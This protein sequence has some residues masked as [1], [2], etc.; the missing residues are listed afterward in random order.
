M[1]KFAFVP[2]FFA[3]ILI[4][5]GFRNTTEPPKGN[6]GA[7]TP[8]SQALGLFGEPTPEH[9]IPN[10]DPA[11]VIRG[12]ELV[13]AGK[14]TAPDGSTTKLQSKWYKCTACHNIEQEEPD[15]TRADPEARLQYAEQQDLPF[16]Q[17]TTFWGIVNRE[18]WYNDDYVK[19]YGAAMEKARNDIR[20]SIQLCS[21]GC[22]QG[23][24]LEEWEVDAVLSYFWSLQLNLGDLN[25]SPKEM[26]VL[27]QAIDN[28]DQH[29]KA[30][31][32]LKSKYLTKSPAHLGEVPED[33]EAGYG[34]TG[35]AEKGE[36]LYER[37][38]LTCHGPKGDS[39]YLTLDKSNY[40][41]SFF[42]RKITNGN[43]F[44]LYEIIRHGTHSVDGHKAYMPY[45]T[46]ERMSDQQIEDLRAYFES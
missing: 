28:P 24:L 31:S 13:K 10:I 14:T 36:V 40:S 5:L 46:K 15:I 11:Q 19:K 44:S 6:L 21:V 9:F 45:Y 35:N 23:R 20:E 26:A 34:L 27:E 3:L 33:K 17:G 4:I 30:K 37:S 32:L 7:Q 43:R 29:A 25:L 16:L 42:T 22:S 12:E 41:K 39:R 2:V 1:K 8:V 18:T 38:C